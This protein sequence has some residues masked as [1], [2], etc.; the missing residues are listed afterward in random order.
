MKLSTFRFTPKDDVK[1]YNIYGVT[2]GE[3]EVDLLTGQHQVSRIIG[4]LDGKEI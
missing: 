2:I 4:K 3:V 1:P